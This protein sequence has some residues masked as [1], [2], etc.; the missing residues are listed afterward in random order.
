MASS[1]P[2]AVSKYFLPHQLRW[3]KDNSQVK[4]WEKSRRIGATYVQAYED[5]RDCAAGKVPAVWFSS[6]DESAAKEYILYCEQ[7]AKLLNIAAKDLGQIVI[8]E[9]NKVTAHT[10]EFANGTRINAL[11]SNPKGFRSKGG[12]V[13]L[14]EFAWHDDPRKLWAA[15][16]PAT[17]WGYPLRILSTHNGKSSLFYKFIDHV[18][19]GKK[20]WSLH[21]TDI[22]LAVKE[23]LADKIIGKTLTDE[24][25]A[26]WVKQVHDD[27]ADEDTWQQEYCCNAVDEATAFLPYELLQTCE[28]S[29]L[30][31]ATKTDDIHDIE[32]DLYVGFDVARRKDLSVIWGIEKI[33]RVKLTRFVIVMEKTPFP[34]QRAILFK[35]LSNP[36]LRRAC[37]DETGIGMQLAEEAEIQFGKT[38][39]EKVYFTGPVKEELAQDLKNAIDDR[40]LRIPDSDEVREDFHSVKKSTTKAGNVRF[41]SE[42]DDEH[43]HA[44]RFWAGALANH[45]AGNVHVSGTPDVQSAKRRE[46][47]EILAGY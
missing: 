2:Q 31:V 39:V 19:K 25:R 3:L 47:H 5:V 23:G 13:V 40:L 46:S 11:S 17:T 18:K 37:I 28:D 12:K 8:D 9:K 44:D 29:T 14:D 16:K 24:E 41:D 42:H 35:V 30:S 32:G 34:M 26:E 45:A 43:G 6:A 1:V 15:A 22:F 33:G 10:I 20:K 36:K 38:R 4:I 7:W 27:C 21:V